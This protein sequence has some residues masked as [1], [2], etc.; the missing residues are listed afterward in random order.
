MEITNGEYET[1]D[2]AT[3][4]PRELNEGNSILSYLQKKK[5]PVSSRPGAE[6]GTIELFTKKTI[7]EL[8][9]ALSDFKNENS[10]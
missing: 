8:R 10:N 1:I 9:E 3:V 7:K 4:L 2:G 5:F 6:D